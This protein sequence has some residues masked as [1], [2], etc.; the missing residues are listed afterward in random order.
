MTKRGIITSTTVKLTSLLDC[1]HL[2]IF[3]PLPKLGDLVYCRRC[4]SAA[5]VT[6]VVTAWSLYCS[7]CQWGKNYG[8]N[9]AGAVRA[10][11]KHLIRFPDHVVELCHNGKTVEWYRS[12]QEP[13]PGIT[14]G[15]RIVTSP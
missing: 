4:M 1:G 12:D 10:G 3:S 14:D 7:Q 2:V 8:D 5:R 11:N 9:R 13:I 15:A 6:R